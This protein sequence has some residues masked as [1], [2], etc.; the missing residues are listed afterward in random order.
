MKWFMSYA[1]TSGISVDYKGYGSTTY[2]EEEHPIAKV[3]RWNEEFGR[4]RQ[5]C[6]IFYRRL[7]KEK[8]EIPEFDSEISF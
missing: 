8:A 6:L 4:E 3:Q 1:W 7:E 5:F 2:D